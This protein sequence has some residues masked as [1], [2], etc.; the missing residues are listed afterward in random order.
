MTLASRV[1]PWL[2][3]ALLVRLISVAYW[4]VEPEIRHLDEICGHGGTMVDIGAW[5]GPWARRLAGRASRVV[6]FEPSSLNEVLRRTLPPTAEVVAAGASDAP[7]EAE[8]W[9]PSANGAGRGLSS[10]RRRDIHTTSVTVPLVTLDSRDLRG[11]TFMKIDVD[12]HEVP[13]LRG[14]EQTITRD[15]PRLLIEVEQRVQGEAGVEGVTG[16]LASWGYRGWV[17]SGRHWVP[18]D[19]FPLAANQAKTVATAS[20]GLLRRFLWPFPRYV[21]LVLFLPE[22]QAPNGTAT[23][24]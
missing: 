15:K 22:G 20:T 1:G 8:L 14:A 3:E 7:S 9:L 6:V 4:R 21:N 2:P 12:G 18:L 24:R 5:Y 10:L 23:R 19:D 13:A 16:L 11:V 17:L